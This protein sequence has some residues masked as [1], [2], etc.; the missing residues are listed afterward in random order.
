MFTYAEICSNQT[1]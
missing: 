1:F